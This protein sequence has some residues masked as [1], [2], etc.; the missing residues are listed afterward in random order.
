RD[1]YA[2]MPLVER[3]PNLWRHRIFALLFACAVFLPNLGSF[4]LWDPWE[5]H[6]GEVTRDMIERDAAI[7]PYWGSRARIGTRPPQGNWFWSK[8][9]YIF[10][11]EQLTIRLFG[12]SEFSVR[13]P[14]ALLAIAAVLI[15]F[16]SFSTL[17]DLRTGW[18][19]AVILATSPMF[20]FIG[21]QAQTDMPFVGSLTIALCFFLVGIFKRR[22]IWS[23]RSFFG[24]TAATS[25]FFLLNTVPQWAVVARDLQRPA[26]KKDVISLILHNGTL[27]FIFY[28]VIA[29][30]IV[31]T[32]AIPMVRH[33][34]RNKGFSDE[35]KDRAIRR[36]YLLLF[37][38]FA[39]HATMAKGLLGFML[40]GAIIFFFVAVSTR[41]RLLARAEIFRGIGVF[42]IAGCPWYIAM[43]VKHHPGF[44]QRFVI[45]DH[46]NR[47]GSGVHQIDTGMFE[48]FIKWLG[49]GMFPWVA[50]VPVL[51]AGFARFRLRTRDDALK[52]FLLLWFFVSYTL[53]TVSST[54][55]HHYIF[56]ALPGL[57]FLIALFIR[58]FEGSQGWQARFGAFV[59]IGMFGLVAYNLLADPQ[60]FRN[61]FTY[62]YSRKMAHGDQLPYTAAWADSIF[63]AET[64]G[65][66]RALIKWEW[67]RYETFIKLI[68]VVGS[69][70]LLSFLIARTRRYG[71]YLL[72]A[73]AVVVALWGLN[74]YMPL[75]SP[76]WSQK[77]LFDKYYSEC[78]RI[79]PKPLVREKFVPLVR[80]IPGLRWIYKATHARNKQICREKIVGWLL[81]WRGET[82]YSH[83]TLYKLESDQL[84]PFLRDVYPK[85]D[86]RPMAF[87]IF[88]VKGGVNGFKAR[89][90]NDLRKA[91][92]EMRR[93]D[94]GSILLQ[95]K[96][97]NVTMAFSES[98][99]FELGV[100]TPVL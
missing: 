4:G 25:I 44:Y 60:H 24:I 34:H 84:V 12:L 97:F 45:H 50:F 79:P 86:S 53:F 30:I 55:F 66:L 85:G 19:A 9:I 14:V 95:V 29:L 73:L 58:E 76:H 54:K 93:R 87:Y 3:P 63:L 72:G 20:F 98:M 8:P 52:L 32:L 5:T 90:N 6:Y 80:K 48:H 23:D 15:A 37:Y 43:F 92:N 82:F 11:S 75:L 81:T 56:P 26:G 59:V 57:A 33:H 96:R 77:Y 83:N 21:R 7:S 99:Y 61:L 70:G 94:P 68:G 13:L 51:L 31:L 1:D 69:V 89:L 10:W 62:Q 91:Q 17:I 64:N 36:Y 78:E 16:W 71:V 2:S 40:P 49:I 35:F 74:Y 22:Q 27:H 42:L 100:A 39:G 88:G 46:F 67:L 47:L 41:W 65:I 28:A 38:L 18:L